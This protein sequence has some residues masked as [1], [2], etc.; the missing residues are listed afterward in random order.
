MREVATTLFGTPA[1]HWGEV[2]TPGA[3]N[4]T[5]FDV[6][7]DIKLNGHAVRKGTYSVWF[8]VKKNADWTMVLDPEVK[9]YHMNPPDSSSAQIRFPIKPEPGPFTGGAHVFGT[10]DSRQWRHAA[11]SVGTREDSDRH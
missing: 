2:W 5:S 8:V 6:N 11:L 3:N 7:K 10:V 9:R 4:A 1:V